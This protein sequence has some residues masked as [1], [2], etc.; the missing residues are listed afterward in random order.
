ME[1]S[2]GAPDPDVGAMRSNVCLWQLAV[3]E[4]CLV[5]PLILAD[6]VDLEE[7]LQQRLNCIRTVSIK[8]FYAPIY[9]KTF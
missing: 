3:N 7:L 4:C 2:V 6:Y 1:V 9:F 8:L 5:E